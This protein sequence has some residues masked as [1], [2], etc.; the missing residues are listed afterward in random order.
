[1]A[2][3]EPSPTV[4]TILLRS[5]DERCNQRYL[6]ELLVETAESYERELECDRELFQVI[7]LDSRG[8]PHKRITAR[9]AEKLLSE[10]S[11]T[12]DQDTRETPS[13][14]KQRSIELAH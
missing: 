12:C 10:A 11:A 14:V 7:A 1:M 4:A 2:R 5:C 8:I 13:A 6:I 3:S 9:N